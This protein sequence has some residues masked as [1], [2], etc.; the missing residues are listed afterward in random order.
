MK[1][2]LVEKERGR[3]SLPKNESLACGKR[4]RKVF[5]GEE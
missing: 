5:I 2:L 4:A 1:P 3:Y